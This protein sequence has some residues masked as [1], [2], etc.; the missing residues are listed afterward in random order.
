MKITISKLLEAL[1]VKEGGPG[2]GPQKG[3][4][5]SKKLDWNDMD[6]GEQDEAFHNEKY[7]HI[8]AL[9]KKAKGPFGTPDRE[10]IVDYV[11]NNWNHDIAPDSSTSEIADELWDEIGPDGGYG[12]QLPEG[13]KG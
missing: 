7:K 3:A 12:S 10:D 13:G 6:D 8:K 1:G 11:K 5:H 9:K 2:S 4:V